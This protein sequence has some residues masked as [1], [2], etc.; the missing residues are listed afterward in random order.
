MRTAV[1]TR[2]GDPVIVGFFETFEGPGPGLETT[3]VFREILKGIGPM[4][5][6]WTW[7]RAWRFLSR[8]RNAR[9]LYQGEEIVA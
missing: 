9:E 7:V 2:R 3:E 1:R 8:H 5:G 4:G 6:G